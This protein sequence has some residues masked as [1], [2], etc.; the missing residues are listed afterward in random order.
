MRRFCLLSAVRPSCTATVSAAGPEHWVLTS[1]GCTALPLK[2]RDLSDLIPSCV[3]RVMMPMPASRESFIS[4]SQI[5]RLQNSMLRAEL[6]FAVISVLPILLRSLSA[7]LQLAWSAH[8]SRLL[9]RPSRSLCVAVRCGWP[10]MSCVLR[11]CIAQQGCVRL[12]ACLLFI[13]EL[14]RALSAAKLPRDAVS[15]VPA[16]ALSLRPR[17]YQGESAPVLVSIHA[18]WGEAAATG[19]PSDHER[20]AEDKSAS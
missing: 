12:L 13:A 14:D 3:S 6:R 5:A 7:S 16:V 19:K 8:P 2:E 4:A 15:L 20:A 18:L 17:L 11:A 1:Y 10:M 9:R